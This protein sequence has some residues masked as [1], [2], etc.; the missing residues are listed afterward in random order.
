MAKKVSHHA[1]MHA[2]AQIEEAYIIFTGLSE[3][4]D[5]FKDP[6]MQDMVMHLNPEALR[7]KFT[8]RLRLA[9]RAHQLAVR[10]SRVLLAELKSRDTDPIDT[11]PPATQRLL[12]EKLGFDGNLEERFQEM[13]Q[14]L[15]GLIES[16]KTMA[17]SFQESITWID[18]QT[19]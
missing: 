11:Q 4:P 19:R 1:F 17:D 3:I 9:K 13:Q 10:G 18:N 15:T 16:L 14:D 8:R 7:V 12:R 2:Q 6:E 5:F